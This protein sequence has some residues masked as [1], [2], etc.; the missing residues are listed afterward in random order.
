MRVASTLQNISRPVVRLRDIADRAG[1]SVTAVSLALKDSTEIGPSTR[2]KIRK[3]AQ[4]MGYAPPAERPRATTLR[5]PP[6]TRRRFGLLYFGTKGESDTTHALLSGATAVASQIGARIEVMLLT[7]TTTDRA[8]V[9]SEAV[10]FGRGVNGLLVWGHVDRSLLEALVRAE[11]PYLVLGNTSV[12]PGEIPREYIHIVTHDYMGMGWYATETLIA[13]GHRR[14]GFV[15]E[16][17]P[18]R[19]YNST[20][21]SGYQLA[22]READLPIDKSL[23]FIGAEPGGAGEPA[24]SAML[25]LKSAPTAYVIS[26]IVAAAQ[27]IASL[28]HHRALPSKSAFVIGGERSQVDRYGLSDY[29]MVLGSPEEIA[30]TGLFALNGA[31]DGAPLFRGTLQIP[32]ETMNLK[33]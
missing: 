14:I 22:H 32:F 12:I 9:Q 1:F 10:R 3:L 5:P 7:D 24:A 21:Y 28:K 26:D 31:A 30:R 11:I 6:R 4:E 29:P 27:F 20:W 19:M 23:C 8:R 13:A 18:P 16:T 17:M 2:V 25:R 15:C 33:S